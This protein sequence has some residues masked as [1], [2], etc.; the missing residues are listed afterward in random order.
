MPRILITL[1]PT[2]EY[3]DEIRFIS[4]SSSGKMGLALAYEA[5]K[6]GFEVTIVSGP[7][8]LPYPDRAS[9]LSVT[10][11]KEMLDETVKELKRT[12][13][14]L[15]ISAAAIADYTPASKVK[16]KIK[17]KNAEL[18]ISLNPTQ[19]LTQTLKTGFPDTPIVAFKAETE[20]SE[21]EL[22]LRAKTKLNHEGLDLIIANDISKFKMGSDLNQ[23][24][25]I[26]KKGIVSISDKA[27][28]KEIA[29]YIFNKILGQGILRKP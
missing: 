2:R 3:I 6:R 18:M 16:G 25:I 29:E 17:S 26:D 22:I 8:S 28:K 14:N 23:V 21:N 4:N 12:H 5:L 9:V 27:S 11:A 24:F 19:K 7:I 20:V 1:G 10:S 15:L 13:Y